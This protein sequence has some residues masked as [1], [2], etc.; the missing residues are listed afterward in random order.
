[1]TCV[2]FLGVLFA[3]FILMYVVPGDPVQ[4]FVGQRASEETLSALRKEWGLDQGLAIQFVKY[5]GRILKGDLGISYFTHESVAQGF[6]ERFPYTFFLASLAILI[7]MILGVPA[8]IFSALHENSWIDKA[9][10]LL[11]LAGISLPVFWAGILLLTAAGQLDTYPVVRS[12]DP[13]VFNILLAGLVLGV[14]P[15]ALLARITR[16][17]VK[18]ILSQDFVLAAWARGISRTKII[19]YHVFR[20]AL[21]TILTTLALDFGSLLSGAAITETIFGIPG[22]GKFALT[23]LSRRDYPVIMGMVVFSAFI[24]IATNLIVDLIIP[25]FNPK[26]RKISHET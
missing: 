7:G 25:I 3:T 22:I 26:L 16:E 19:F 14:R 15:V 12:L 2:V 9:L 11:T 5:T 20:N 17:Q 6:L 1:M 10:M 8:G 4:N 13:L 23:G 21:P 18:E 24:F